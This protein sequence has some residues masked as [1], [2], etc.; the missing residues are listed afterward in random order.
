MGVRNEFVST[1]GE[2]V[3]LGECTGGWSHIDSSGLIEDIASELVTV[4]T[5]QDQGKFICASSNSLHRI[6]YISIKGQL[7]LSI[8]F[9]VLLYCYLLLFYR[10]SASADP[11]SYYGHCHTGTFRR[12]S[13]YVCNN[14]IID[15]YHHHYP[16]YHF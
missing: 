9:L 5:P 15:K 8:Q 12:T 4:N 16:Q 3:S 7:H 14:Y 6:V 1:P 13:S 10:L 11:L 2:T